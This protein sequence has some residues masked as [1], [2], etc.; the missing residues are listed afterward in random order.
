MAYQTPTLDQMQG[1][2]VSLFKALLPDRNIGSRFT[3]A[4]KLVRT[5]AGAATDVNANVAFAQRDVMADTAI[6][7]ALD[8]FLFIFA[9]GGLKYRKG[10]T[11]ARKAAAGRV[12]GSNGATSALGDQLIH[13]SSGL[14]FQINNSV[15]IPGAGYFDADILAVSTGSATRLRKGETLEYLAAPAGITTQVALQLDL[16][17]DGVDVEAD[18]DARN[19][20]LT[21]LSTPAAGGNQADYVGWMTAVLGISKAY[22]YPARAGL[23]T[24]DV[25]ALHAGLGINRILTTLEASALLAVLQTLAPAQVAGSGGSLRILTAVGG[26]TDAAMLANVELTIAPNGLPQY[27]MDW[28]DTTA[29]TVLAYTAGTRTVQFTGA[30]P[31]TMQAGHRIALRGVASS[32]DGAPMTILALSSTDSI[33][34]QDTPTV[35]PAATDVV[36]AAGPLTKP[37]RD[38]ILAHINGDT[39]YLAA[40]GPLPAATAASKSIST[41]NLQVLAEG[42]G[43]ANPL[44]AYGSWSGSLLRGQLSKIAMMTPGVRNQAVITPVVDQDATDYAFPL[45]ASIGLLTPGYVLV[46]KG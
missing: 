10:A 33:I 30:R 46:R 4:W 23:G 26:N 20:L 27:A 32:Q 29:P 16:D 38:A 41:V 6:K 13:R 45:D 36:Y 40:T 19:R 2:L 14:L 28:D 39:L 11:P 37:I 21:A 18:G 15:V 34:L 1:F 7:A 44:G 12:R 31:A 3:P 42:I 43:T 35:S 9:P 25:V 8:R 17:Q 22:C 5:I 24:I